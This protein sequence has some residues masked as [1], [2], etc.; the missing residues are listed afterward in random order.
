MRSEVV[1]QPVRPGLQ[2]IEGDDGARRMQDDGGLAL[3]EVFA[4]LH[5]MTLRRPN[6]TGVKWVA[7]VAQDAWSTSEFKAE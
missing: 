7:R 1:G 4:E 2:F 5:A 6:L 3:A